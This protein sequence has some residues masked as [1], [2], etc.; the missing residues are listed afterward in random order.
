[1]KILLIRPNKNEADK[2]ALEAKGFNVQIDEY[3]SINQVDNPEGAKNMLQAIKKPGKKWL[4]ATSTNAMDYWQRQLP[5][6]ALQQAITSAK[7]IHF[8]AIGS[9]TKSILEA[10]GA[11]DVITPKSN[12][13]QSL[14]EQLAETEPATVIQPAGSIAMKDIP[15]TLE[16]MGFEM[17]TEVVYSTEEVTETPKSVT[18]I[19][20]NE[21]DAVLFRS[22]SAARAFL[23]FNPNP[24]LKLI[25]A[26]KT[27]AKQLASLG[28]E[29]NL[30]IEKP[31]PESIAEAIQR[32]AENE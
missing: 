24:N 5:E 17:I 10:F 31:D 32:W 25:S 8:G 6:N 23:K 13:G 3:L 28:F 2:Q 9:Q 29:A 1:M 27:T 19:A 21:I 7:D 18:Q 11:K 26:G 30:V 16:P 15:N 4:L 22:P 14:A 12:N 20:N